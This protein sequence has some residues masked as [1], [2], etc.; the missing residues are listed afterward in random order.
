M[1]LNAAFMLVGCNASRSSR[2]ACPSRS[3]R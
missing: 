3:W 1:R 2:G